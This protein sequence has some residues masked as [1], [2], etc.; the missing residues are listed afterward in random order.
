M[1]SVVSV[2]RLTGQD[3]GGEE[4]LYPA[5]EIVRLVVAHAAAGEY[6][7]QMAGDLGRLP[8]GTWICRFPSTVPTTVVPIKLAG[9]GENW[10]IAVEQ[11]DPTRF[12]LRNTVAGGRFWKSKKPSGFEVVIQ[13]SATGRVIGEVTVTGSLFGTPDREFT[14]QAQDTI[15]KLIDE[16]RRELKNVEDR[17]KHPRLIANFPVTVYP[18]HSDG[19]INTPVVGFCRDVSAGGVCILLKDPPATKYFFTA[20]DAVAETAGHAILTRTVR[21]QTSNTECSCGALFRTDL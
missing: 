5:E 9:L 17:R 4:R 20:F 21:V 6:L 7:P 12:V 2:A 10:R 1:R 14:A 11:A 8:D 3:F 18:I 16:V 19:G 15:P 13:L